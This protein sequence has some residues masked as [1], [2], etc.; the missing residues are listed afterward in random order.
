MRF[1]LNFIF[2]GLLFYAISRFFPD[3][4]ET[5]VSWVGALYEFIRDWIIYAWDRIGGSATPPPSQNG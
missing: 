4:F 5:L 2:F 1:I 3:M